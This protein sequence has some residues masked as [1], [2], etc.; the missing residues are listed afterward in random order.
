MVANH[1]QTRKNWGQL[2]TIQDDLV[3]LLQQLDDL[4]LHHAAAHV[5]SALDS[6]KRDRP[7]I[8][9]SP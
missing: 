7:P 1:P 2:Q 5:S 9:P 4:E 6:I 8:A 3:S